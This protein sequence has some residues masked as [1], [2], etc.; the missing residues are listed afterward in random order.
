[1]E[2]SGGGRPMVEKERSLSDPLIKAKAG[3]AAGTGSGMKESTS[4]DR[5][6]DEW[7]QMTT[8]CMQLEY[9]AEDEYQLR[10]EKEQRTREL[11]AVLAAERAKHRQALEQLSVA[12][13]SLQSE[14]QKTLGM[15]QHVSGLVS[16]LYPGQQLPTALGRNGARD[17]SM[18]LAYVAVVRAH[19]V[20][21]ILEQLADLLVG[22]PSS[23]DDG[24]ELGTGGGP[25]P[26]RLPA[27]KRTPEQAK[28]AGAKLLAKY[29]FRDCAV[30]SG[31][32]G[33]QRVDR[34]DP[35]IP[36]DA[37]VWPELRPHF[38]ALLVKWWGPDQAT[39]T[40][41]QQAL[42]KLLLWCQQG[43]AAVAEAATRRTT[44]EEGITK[45]VDAN[46]MVT[47]CC[48]NSL[49][50]H[51]RIKRILIEQSKLNMLHDRY[52]KVITHT[53]ASCGC[54]LPIAD[55]PAALPCS[56]PGHTWPT[57]RTWS[58]STRWC[59]CNGL[60]IAGHLPLRHTVHLRQS[61]WVLSG[62]R[63]SS[64]M[65]LWPP[66]TRARKAPARAGSSNSSGKS[67]T[68]STSASPPR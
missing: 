48:R 66:L 10:I 34:M 43:A 59:K 38:R 67:T 21:S 12:E 17:R 32:D 65:R 37:H 56:S 7:I 41:I 36:A 47:L 9:K 51:Y 57:Q 40:T 26:R 46:D 35:L 63:C 33:S 18:N 30:D 15:M 60:R 58:S 68:S 42:D 8:R 23:R 3:K 16:A 11:E 29:I 19:Q 39:Q 24:D 50:D 53:H 25:G 49:T 64:G 61:V 27:N 54:S 55:S 13:S 4:S 22:P 44:A 2:G 52:L 31:D 5:G 6:H 14:R 1:M 28:R 45:S 20:D 62:T